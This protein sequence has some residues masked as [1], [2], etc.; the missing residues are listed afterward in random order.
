MFQSHWCLT[1]IFADTNQ[2]ESLTD[3]DFAPEVQYA[4]CMEVAAFRSVSTGRPLLWAKRF[5]QGPL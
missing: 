3:A 4:G 5:F 1:S 2:R